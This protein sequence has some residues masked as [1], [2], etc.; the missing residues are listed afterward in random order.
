[1]D[2][3]ELEPLC[4]CLGYEGFNV[5]HV[6]A[7]FHTDLPQFYR[8]G[9]LMDEYSCTDIRRLKLDEALADSPVVINPK[10]ME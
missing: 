9:C 7:Q 6:K 2:G 10:C 3:A 4:C 8:F 1:M 5:A